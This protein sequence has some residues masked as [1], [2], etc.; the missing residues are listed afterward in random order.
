VF[1]G[2]CYYFIG[3]ISQR[4]FSFILSFKIKA[5]KLP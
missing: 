2:G 3:N 1:F 5:L 4:H